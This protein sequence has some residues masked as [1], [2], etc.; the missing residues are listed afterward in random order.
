MDIILKVAIIILG[1][2]ILLFIRSQKKIKYEKMILEDENESLKT[3]NEDI[4]EQLKKGRKINMELY[5]EIN[6]ESNNLEIEN[7]KLFYKNLESELYRKGR[8][9]AF[10]FSVIIVSIDYYEEYK[11]LYTEKVEEFKNRL[12]TDLNY[13]RRKI[14][15]LSRGKKD[16][17][18]ILLLPMTDKDGAAVVIDRIKNISKKYSDNPVI[19]LTIVALEV[20]N[21]EDVN[22]IFFNLEERVKKLQNSG[23]N[24]SIVDKI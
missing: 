4:K 14:D 18:W 7:A 8:N 13:G 12:E 19:S 24:T 11:K 16:D 23:G 1:V 6:N 22:E 5:S 10:I 9:S 2:I 20:E 3:D 21:C 17:S 15:I